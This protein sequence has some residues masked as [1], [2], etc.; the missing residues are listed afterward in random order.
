MTDQAASL[1]ARD[2]TAVWHPFT[3]HSLWGD[4][5]PL[6]IDRAEGMH[7]IDTDGRRYLDGVSSLW[8]SV[9]GHRVPEIDAAVR[10]QL[11]KVAH[12][13]FLGLT[14][15]PGITLAEQL[16]ALAPPTADAPSGRTAGP[17]RRVFYAGDGSSAVEAALKMAYQAAAQRGEHRPLFVS[18][19]EGY[20]GDTLGAVSVGGIATF[21][22][23]YRQILLRTRQIPSPFRVGTA[24]ALEALQ[25]LLDS[26]GDQVCA[27]II[28]PMVQAAAGML[29]HDADFVRGARELSRQ[30]GALLIADEVATG[31]GRTGM[32]WAV[33][34]AGVTPDLLTC[35]KGLSGGY[36]P[37]SAVLATEEVYASFLGAPES[38]RTF[39]HGHTYTANPLA[40]AAAIA[41]LRLMAEHDTVRRAARVGERLG[42]LLAPLNE[43]SGVV[44]VRR[45]GTMAGV[46]VASRGSRTGFEICRLARKRGVLLR[47]LSDVVVLMPP[48]AIGDEDLDELAAVTVDCVHEVVSAHAPAAGPAG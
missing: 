19:A 48:L 4:D 26:E 37:L 33:E 14:H 46:E 42:A 1:V 36:L 45:C 23:A 17:L 47:P 12:S 3:Q 13:T 21:H 18:V 43:M 28:E 24:A 20:H 25:Q 31:L 11:A 22:A 35:G 30:A 16:I 2:L 6:V 5:E 34:H 38:D 40:C 7:L 41:N 15:E 9:H 8:V 29:T 39:F 44:Q 10:D 27:V 32:M